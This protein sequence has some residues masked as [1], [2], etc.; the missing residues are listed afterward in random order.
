MRTILK[1]DGPKSSCNNFAN[2]EFQ[3]LEL[4]AGVIFE[5]KVERHS[6]SDKFYGNS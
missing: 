4:A 5:N 1:K 3:K 6:V 2:D